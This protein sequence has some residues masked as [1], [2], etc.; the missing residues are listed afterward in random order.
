MNERD[1]LIIIDEEINN[2]CEL[3]KSKSTEINN[4]ILTYISVLNNVA[5]IAAPDGRFS[6][7]LKEFIPLARTLQQQTIILSEKTKEISTKYMQI[8]NEHGQFR[9]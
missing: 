9:E 7:S 6:N 5:K 2:Y 4:R 1:E 8:I 3:I